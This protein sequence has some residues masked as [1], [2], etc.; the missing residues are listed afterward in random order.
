M[1]ILL[2]ADH[3]HFVDDIPTSH[4]WYRELTY[5]LAKVYPDGEANWKAIAQSILPIEDL[6]DPEVAYALW[7]G[8]TVAHFDATLRRSPDAVD[9]LENRLRHEARRL[10]ATVLTIEGDT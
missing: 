8:L 9:L 10:G 1:V 4:T 7:R 3:N 5:T 2:D 6:V